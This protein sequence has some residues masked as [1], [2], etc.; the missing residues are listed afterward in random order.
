MGWT[1]ATGPQSTL[2]REREALCEVGWATVI[3]QF[4]GI[5]RSFDKR[6][7]TAADGIFYKTVELRTNLI[8][9]VKETDC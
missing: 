2:T 5:E 3:T 9:K 1:M 4:V 8:Q 6:Y 7:P